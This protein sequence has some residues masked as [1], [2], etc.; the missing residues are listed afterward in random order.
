MIERQNNKK[1]IHMIKWGI[2]QDG[3]TIR[4]MKR[5]GENGKK[6]HFTVQNIYFCWLWI[7]EKNL[8]LLI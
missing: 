6:Y 5:N 2:N 4:A 7:F 1:N 3:K 8:K